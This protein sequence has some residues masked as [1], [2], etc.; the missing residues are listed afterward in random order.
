MIGKLWLPTFLAL[1]WAVAAQAQVNALPSDRHIL[2]YGDAEARA[3]PDRFKIK[4]SFDVV[5]PS[6]DVARR[7]VEA[8]L[9]RVLDAIKAAGVPDGEIVATSMEIEPRERYDSKLEDHVFEGIGVSRELTARFSDI[10]AL[11]KFIA[12]LETSKEVQVSG[13]ETELQDEQALHRALRA[14]SI[15][16]ARLKAEGMARDFGV[17]LAG[18]YSVSDVAPQFQYG[19]REGSWPSTYLWTEDGESGTLDSIMVTGS[20]LKRVALQTGYVTYSDKIYAVFLIA[21]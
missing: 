4:V 1:S 19:V 8:N 20:R 14:K 2:V 11:E 7:K 16:S 10:D 5:D 12:G 13:I 9:G 6:A 21:D 15:A 18:L 3:I 17:R